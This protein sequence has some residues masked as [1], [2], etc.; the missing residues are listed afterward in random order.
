MVLYIIIG[1]RRSFPLG[2]GT[3]EV[4]GT[5]LGFIGLTRNSR[6]VF[7]NAGKARL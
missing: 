4:Q 2:I 1:M 3:I 7:F 6:A 5:S